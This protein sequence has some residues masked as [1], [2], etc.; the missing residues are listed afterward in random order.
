MKIQPATLSPIQVVIVMFIVVIV[1]A[2]A[3]M[4]T[5]CASVNVS[6]PQ[7]DEWDTVYQQDTK[8]GVYTE[9]DTI[10]GNDTLYYWKRD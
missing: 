10:I 5:S 7:Y 3:G 2:I 6:E 8:H 9:Y 1:L 4:L